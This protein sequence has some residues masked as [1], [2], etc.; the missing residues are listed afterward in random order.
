MMEMAIYISDRTLVAGQPGDA[1]RSPLTTYRPARPARPFRPVR[2]VGDHPPHCRDIDSIP[3]IPDHS[4]QTRRSCSHCC[5][6][7]RAHP[8]ISEHRQHNPPRRYRQILRIAPPPKK[9]G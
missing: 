9:E 3:L 4:C 1:S 6:H 7:F 8:H 5:D 2:R